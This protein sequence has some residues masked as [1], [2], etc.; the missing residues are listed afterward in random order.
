MEFLAKIT[1]KFFTIIYN[2]FMFI[3]LLP[4][5]IVKYFNLFF[6]YIIKL[7]LKES[8]EK[9]QKR[10]EREKEREREKEE[11]RK[12]A[13]K[14]IRE[15]NKEANISALKGSHIEKNII[16]ERAK[17]STHKM[18]KEELKEEHRIAKEKIKREKQR[19]KEEA[20]K[21]KRSILNQFK[22]RNFFA[23]RRQKK[24]DSKRKVLTLDINSDD[25]KRS[26]EKII[27]RYIGKNE[28]GKIEKG[29]FQGYSK[30]DV[31]SYLLSEGYEV[32]EIKAIAKANIFN[33]DISLNRPI[34]KT[35][36]VFY[37]TQLSTYIKA[38]IPLVDSI[39]ILTNQT[40]S[41]G[42][43]TIWKS[44]VYELTMGTSL[45]EAM[46]RCGNVFPKLL[47]NMIR[48]AEMTGDLSEVL[49]EQ[50]EYYRTTEKSKKEMINAM[51]YPMCIF[52][53]SI[54]I[55]IF[56]LLYV[57]PQFVDIYES[58]GADLPW[59]TI[60]LINIS[61]FV[62]ENILYILI[63]FVIAIILFIILYK[64]NS[65]FKYSVEYILMHIP[66]IKDVII[67]NE[68]T[69]FSKTFATLINNNIFITDSM[70][71]LS[72]ITEN[73]IYK[74]II[75]DAVENLARGENISESFYDHW[76]FPDIAYQMIVTG[77]KTGQLGTMMDKVGDYY[78]DEHA[79]AIAQIKVFIEPVLIVFL[80]L[81]VGGILLA[82]ILPMFSMYSQLI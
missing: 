33:T 3:I 10:L 41:K 51:M 67:Y 68:I 25:S 65:S 63:G 20:R 80:A 53:F 2:I 61:N 64:N 72:R 35:L 31:H 39:K 74:T 59:I 50:A 9:K 18:S 13:Q 45:S 76:A 27:F 30:L 22:E 52:I 79:N 47:I 5:N 7:A 82:V 62:S 48:T 26:N 32:Y 77:E 66:V 69:M 43:K 37:L 81:G 78:H 57:I 38:G 29:T 17:T 49:D 28:K 34:K 14:Y 58:I 12:R 46:I 16:E 19:Q 71:I 70:D 36:L 54:A 60:L 24:L 6:Y 4:L 8:P 44:I 1:K 42:M 55:L 73:E 11:E 75:Y 15:K 23:I 40:K 56:I 21:E